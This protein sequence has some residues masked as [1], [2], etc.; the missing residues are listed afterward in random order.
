MVFAE[1]YPVRGVSRIGVDADGI[2][3]VTS[4]ASIR[5][6]VSPGR[7]VRASGRMTAGGKF[8]R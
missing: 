5:L 8:A 7:K 3:V 2:E 4:H 6:G 1:K